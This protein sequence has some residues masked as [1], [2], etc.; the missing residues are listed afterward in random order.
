M[1]ED[2]K[3]ETGDVAFLARS[4]RVLRVSAARGGEGFKGGA[5]RPGGGVDECI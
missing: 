1:R 4:R 5:E 3:V 2:V